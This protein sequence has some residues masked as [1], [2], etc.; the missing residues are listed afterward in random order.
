MSVPPATPRAPEA[1][2]APEEPAV[3][4]APRDAPAQPLHEPD[5]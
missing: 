1:H 5:P 4:D 2:D 3:L